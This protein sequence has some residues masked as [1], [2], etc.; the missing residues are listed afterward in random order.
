MLKQVSQLRKGEVVVCGRSFKAFVPEIPLGSTV[1]LVQ[2]LFQYMN[3]TIVYTH[4]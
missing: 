1:G 4:L 2:E 3:K